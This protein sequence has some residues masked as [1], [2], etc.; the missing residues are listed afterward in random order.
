MALVTLDELRLALKNRLCKEGMAET[1]TEQLAD[2]VMSFFGFSDQAID[3]RLT[4]ED[5]DVFY[6]LEEEGFLTTE[7]EEVSVEKGKV[8]RIHYWILKTDQIQRM[9]HAGNDGI[10]ETD[11]VVLCYDE[12]PDDCWQRGK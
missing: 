8:W 4:S 9:A 7:Q 6:M 12:V 11:G 2:Y 1:D 5:R 3:N 10:S